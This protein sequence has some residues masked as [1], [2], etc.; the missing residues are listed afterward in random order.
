MA[1]LSNTAVLLSD[2]ASLAEL[3]LYLDLLGY[4]GAQT[5]YPALHVKVGSP[6]DAAHYGDKDLLMLGTYGDLAAVPA[7]AGSLPFQFHEGGWNLS[8]RAQVV[9][10][11]LRWFQTARDFVEQKQSDSQDVSV[12]DGVLEQIQSPF[13]RGHAAVVLLGD[14]A[15]S[16]E[17]MAT[18]LM[19]DLPHDGIQGSVSLWQGGSFVSHAY[20]TPD[21]YLGDASLLT[22][23]KFILP[24]YPWAL[25][26]GLI[27][28]LVLLSLWLNACIEARI[29]KRMMG[30][31]FDLDGNATTPVN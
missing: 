4:F 25:M 15:P 8:A 2:H 26:V 9:E 20:S 29:R 10:T 17:S 11:L 27:A 23:F 24:D 7:I 12:P 30:V 1:D 14:S 6:T 19:A 22:R 31:E 13:A 3:T 16:V 18:R 28:F 5:G 21:Y